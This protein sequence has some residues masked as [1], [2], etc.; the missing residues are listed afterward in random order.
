MIRLL[1]FATVLAALLPVSAPAQF[2]QPLPVP[3]VGCKNYR[4][5]NKTSFQVQ[6]MFDALPAE[7][8]R[9]GP[10]QT[11]VYNKKVYCANPA[12]VV[13]SYNDGRTTRSIGKNIALDITKS[14]FEIVQS[15]RYVFLH[16]EGDRIPSGYYQ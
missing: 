6:V 3:S 11:V 2:A 13:A 1:S 14:R 10:G 7:T 16:P 9:L 4:L 5:T 12:Y 8:Y 15:G